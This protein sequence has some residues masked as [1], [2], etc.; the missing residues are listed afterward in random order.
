VRIHYLLDLIKLLPATTLVSAVPDGAGYRF[1]S[2][3]G[4]HLAGVGLNFT[5]LDAAMD[6][7]HNAGLY[8]GF[9]IMGN[10]G[11]NENRTD[12][13]FTDFSDHKQIIGW[14]EL[15]HT[16]AARYIERYGV[17]VVRQW[18]W[19]VILALCHCYQ[20]GSESKA[21]VSVNQLNCVN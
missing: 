7:L 14:K 9:E 13:L 8:P 16:V 19:C 18:R 10:P 15:V 11:N 3:A 12:R 6:Q 2:A 17:D 4:K 20:G 1:S 5:A 21:S